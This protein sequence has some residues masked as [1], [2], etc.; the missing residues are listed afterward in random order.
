LA[1][2]YMAWSKRPGEYVFP[3]ECDPSYGE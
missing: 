1:A 2:R 3:Y